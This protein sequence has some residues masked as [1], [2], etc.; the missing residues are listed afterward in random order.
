MFVVGVA[1]ILEYV[2]HIVDSCGQVPYLVKKF[3]ECLEV[4]V[5]I[6]DDSSRSLDTDSVDVM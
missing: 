3:D 4:D 6:E 2:R 1:G 5:A